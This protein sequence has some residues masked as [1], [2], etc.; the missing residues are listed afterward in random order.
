[1]KILFKLT[2]AAVA[3]IVCC[4]AVS[5]INKPVAPYNPEQ[6]KGNVRVS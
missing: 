1:M 3:V 6:I 2:L 4:A 5:S